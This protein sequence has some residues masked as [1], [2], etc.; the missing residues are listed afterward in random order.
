M[1]AR[2][3]NAAPRFDRVSPNQNA[4]T[5]L[6]ERRGDE[7]ASI[8]ALRLRTKALQAV[9]GGETL[10]GVVKGQKLAVNGVPAGQ[11]CRRTRRSALLLLLVGKII[12]GA[13][14]YNVLLRDDE[15]WE[16]EG[17]VVEVATECGG[18]DL[19]YALAEAFVVALA[20]FEGTVDEDVEP[21]GLREGTYNLSA[22]RSRSGTTRSGSISQGSNRTLGLR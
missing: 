21:G 12:R 22:S 18:L 6:H 1:S 15:G 4:R 9:E 10:P 8:E 14:S 3:I 11:G 17:E 19:F 7:D 20:S 2:Q 16:A 5:G 13:D